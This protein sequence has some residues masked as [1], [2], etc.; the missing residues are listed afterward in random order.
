[1]GLDSVRL[2]P[3]PHT[4][5]ECLNP[6][7]SS[8]MIT[9]HQASSGV[10]RQFEKKTWPDLSFPRWRVLF[11]KCVSC[12]LSFFVD[13][14]VFKIRSPIFKSEAKQIYTCIHACNKTTA[15]LFYIYSSRGTSFWVDIIDTYPLPMDTSTGIEG[16]SDLRAAAL[17]DLRS[18]VFSVSKGWERWLMLV[19]DTFLLYTVHQYFR[20]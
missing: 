9:R 2:D 20:W 18:Q 13:E 5:P 14:F 17:C 3:F 10:A 16:P 19:S 4:T 1:M 6:K 11:L 7:K 15:G 8:K 12:I